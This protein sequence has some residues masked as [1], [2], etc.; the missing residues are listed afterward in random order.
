M[1]G[2]GNLIGAGEMVR[3]ASERHGP[4]GLARNT[5][6]EALNSTG[7]VHVTG[8][9][10]ANFRTYLNRSP[11][12][13]EIEDLKPGLLADLADWVASELENKPEQAV[14]IQAWV[15]GRDAISLLT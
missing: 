1:Y 5:V 15:E 10:D 12:D 2:V 8:P 7:F 3:A 14:Q 6:G 9:L 13:M 4:L 11:V